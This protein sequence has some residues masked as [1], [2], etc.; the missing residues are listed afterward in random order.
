M[1]EPRIIIKF[2]EI[3]GQSA[4]PQP[5]PVGEGVLPLHGGG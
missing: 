3:H 5:S 4:S 1:N 2:M